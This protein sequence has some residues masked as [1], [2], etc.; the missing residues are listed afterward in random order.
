M[1]REVDFS[2]ARRGVVSDVR[3]GTLTRNDVCDA[4]PELLRAARNMGRESTA[5]CPICGVVGLRYIAYVYGDSLKAPGGRAV[6]SAA[7][8]RKLGRAHDQLQCYD[9]EVCL[10]CSWN[11]MIRTFPTGRKN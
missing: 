5:A 11:F 1:R 8:L 10:E 6:A 3:K 7:E 4:H 2:L 9:V